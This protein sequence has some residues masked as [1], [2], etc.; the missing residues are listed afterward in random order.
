MD[1]A[2]PTTAADSGGMPI[3]IPL[4]AVTTYVTCP[5]RFMFEYLFGIK[6]EQAPDPQL[7]WAQ[8]LG[9]TFTWIHRELAAT[10]L[11]KWGSILDHWEVVWNR[12]VL[13]IKPM[14]KQV[15]YGRGARHLLEVFN[16]L[17]EHLTVIAL[18]Y[19]IRKEYGRFVLTLQIPVIRLMHDPKYIRPTVQIIT[20][21]YHSSPGAFEQCRR[22]DYAAIKYSIPKSIRDEWHGGDNKARIRCLTYQPRIPQLEEFEVDPQLGMQADQWIQWVFTGIQEGLFYPRAG[23]SCVRC[24][25]RRVCDVKYA[26]TNSLNLP[27]PTRTELMRR[28]HVGGHDPVEARP[29]QADPPAGDGQCSDPQRVCPSGEEYLPED[30][31]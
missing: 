24:P 16:G 18:D 20:Y 29:Q 26:S 15:L 23:E 12:A 21:D 3:L 19:P 11:I 13:P 27:G 4:D 9:D 17:S 30:L 2:G 6:I 28:L 14:E 5:L 25:Y 7:L 22:L 31:A 1:S 8:A 10:G